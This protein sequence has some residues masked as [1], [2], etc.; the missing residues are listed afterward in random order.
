M[1][2]PGTVR[3]LNPRSRGRSGAVILALLITAAGA[4]CAPSVQA[5]SPGSETSTATPLSQEEFADIQQ[6]LEKLVPLLQQGTAGTAEL[7]VDSLREF[8]CLR[9]E[10]KEQHKQTRWMSELSATPQDASA[11][12]GALEQVV[13][14]LD[15]EG[16]TVDREA[17]DSEET[18]GI[19]RE[20][21]LSNGSLRATVTYARGRSNPEHFVTVFLRTSCLE[22]PEDHRMQ[23]SPLDPDYGKSSQYYPDGA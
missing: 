8:S 14:T 11:A 9:P 7:E 13:S 4:G 15:Q 20:I 12:N 18:D 5:E 10:I 1:E 6:E 2:R 23:R 19:V 3:K 21:V 16:W 17:G 22:H